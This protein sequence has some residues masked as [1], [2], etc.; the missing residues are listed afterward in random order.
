M[1]EILDRDIDLQLPVNPILPDNS[2]ES[3]RSALQ[4]IHNAIIILANN[5]VL[6]TSSLTDST[7]G[8]VTDDLAAVAGSGADAVIN[9]NFAEIYNI[10]KTL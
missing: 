10:L 3:I 2:V 6:N 4:E 8:S 1:P 7:G 9:D 5:T